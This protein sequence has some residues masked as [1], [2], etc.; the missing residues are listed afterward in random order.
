MPA[1]DPPPKAAARRNRQKPARGGLRFAP[2]W[3]NKP[4]SRQRRG[5]LGCGCSSGVEHNLAKVGVE[6]SNPF[7]RSRQSQGLRGTSV[8]FPG[9]FRFLGLGG[10]AL[11]SRGSAGPCCPLRS[12][13]RSGA[14]LHSPS[15]AVVPRPLHPV[16]PAEPS[17]F[18]GRGNPASPP[19]GRPSRRGFGTQS[20]RG[21]SP[22]RM[23]RKLPG[24]N[25]E[26]LRRGVKSAGARSSE[27]E[28]PLAMAAA[29]LR[30]ASATS[31]SA[32]TLPEAEEHRG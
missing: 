18:S 29:S 10:S 15:E 16:H 2:P 32:D 24:R 21:S 11:F 12:D 19:P 6:G 9:A 22:C 14:G 5:C 25:I 1:R 20:R 28:A 8:G 13:E 23:I 3:G 30:L 27:R 4:A 26:K 31:A 17:C 7:A